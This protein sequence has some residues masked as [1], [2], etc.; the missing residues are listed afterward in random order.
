MRHYFKLQ[1]KILQRILLEIGLPLLLLYLVLPFSFFLGSYFLFELVHFE[2]LAFAYALLPFF[3][4]IRLQNI[5][6][7]NFLKNLYSRNQYLKIRISE[8]ILIALPFLIILLFE[9]EFLAC[10]ICLSGALVLTAV[11]INQS[12]NKALP[13]PFYKSPFEFIAGF[14]KS[15]ILFPLVY[16]LLIIGIV[17]GNFNLALSS[18]FLQ[19]F[20]CLSYYNKPDNKYLVWIHKHEP[21]GFLFHKLK[22]S[23]RHFSLLNIPVVLTLSIYR[24][25]AYYVLI[26]S[27]ILC[28][29]YLALMVLAKYAAFPE[30]INMAQGILLAISIAFPPFALVLIFHFYKKAI[31]Q[32]TP[33]LAHDSH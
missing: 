10:L 31:H 4:I 12:L 20:I 30:E 24:P 3:P 27:L 11:N 17:K 32:L 18:L 2:Y 23:F 28:Y 14:R 19:C 29:L 7:Q 5:D 15:I 21:K 25:G 9:Q 6:R 26:V 16:A 1:F 33:V 13:T 8:N 22:I